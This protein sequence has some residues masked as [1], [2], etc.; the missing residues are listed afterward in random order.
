M[1]F[2]ITSGDIVDSHRGLEIKAGQYGAGKFYFEVTGLGS[3]LNSDDK[4]WSSETVIPAAKQC[5]DDY[6]DN[7]Q[8]GQYHAYF[9]R[10]S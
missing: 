8:P 2:K 1:S 6:F 9:K 5:I 10:K 7:Y 3:S 4:M